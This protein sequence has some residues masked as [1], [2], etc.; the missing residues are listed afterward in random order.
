MTCSRKHNI[1]TIIA[2][3]GFT[4]ILL[5]VFNYAAGQ[6][7]RYSKMSAYVRQIAQSRQA[8][9]TNS[10]N[11]Q[12]E[13]TLTAFIKINASADEV[14]SCYSIKPL[15]RKGNIYI[16]AIPVS[17]L[18]DVSNDA[19]VE[20]IEAGRSHLALMDSTATYTNTTYA[21]RGTSLPQPFTGKGV[22]MGVVDVGFDLT[23]P[24]FYD[25]TATTYRIKSLWDQLSTDTVGST[26]HVG[27]DYTTQQ[28]L[29]ALGCTTD[30]TEQ[31]HGTH[32]LGIAAGSGYDSP[33]R[34][35]AYESDICLVANAIGENAHFIDSA[36]LYKYNYATDALAF[37]YI[38]DY[39]E[40]VGKPCVISFSEGS[41]QD[42]QGYDQLY[43]AFIDS[44][45]GAGKI[46]VSAAGNNGGKPSYIIKPQGMASAGSFIQKWGTRS[47][48][49]TIKA[50]RHFRLKL[51]TYSTSVDTIS[52]STSDVLHAADSTLTIADTLSG[53]Y[54]VKITAYANSIDS[55][56]TVYDVQVS[57][58]MSIG[59]V[60]PLSFQV[61]GADAKVEVFKTTGE[62]VSN[63]LDP[64][65]CDGINAYNVF[66]PSSCKSVICVGATAWRKSYVNYMGE[67]KETAAKADGT[68]ADYS[69]VGPTFEGNIKPDVVA[70]GTNVISSYSSYYLENNPEASDIS[71]DVEHF[72]F[73]NRTYAWNA[74]TGTSMA[75]PVV[76]G[77]IALWLEA[78]PNL[79]PQDIMEVL[80][81]TC[82]KPEPTLTYPNNHYGY[83]EI[84]V[85]AGLLNILGINGIA[86]HH[87]NHN[88]EAHF[89]FSHG[90]AVLTLARQSTTDIC[91]RIYST[92]GA[93]IYNKVLPKGE[94]QY[95]ITLPPMHSG[96]YAIS[97]N[98]PT[99]STS[100]LFRR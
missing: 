11:H 3:V 81:H 82:R 33:Y 92:G 23:H 75:C 12:P 17:R 57:G 35:M 24:N 47:V 4:L 56:E 13:Q 70:P 68:L 37:K 99:V 38:F 71:S 69:S 26:L 67:R 76:A 62:W 61:I 21:Y 28:E 84:D 45:V 46:L 16:A 2:R 41:Y 55:A 34:G 77:A 85:Y 59:M 8:T 22:V 91:V 60:T 63:S 64:T 100:A 18:G 83:G 20:R 49:F 31:T 30:G 72:N 42:F 53:G 80:K 32:T 66:S 79:S 19:R 5:F 65:L 78:N 10:L 97:A 54:T 73:N 25:S 43:Y 1:P 58:P 89:T 87:T 44:L 52:I 14:M 93:I 39:A 27:R 94:S 98:S 96:V 50:A 29:L 88:T 7:P 74:N 9:R 6:R 95:H 48:Y 90:N 15:A 36:D 86:T 40:S 51:A